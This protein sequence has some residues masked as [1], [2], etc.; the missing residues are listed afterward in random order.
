M[1]SQRHKLP[2]DADIR[3]QVYLQSCIADFRRKLVIKP[4]IDTIRAQTRERVRK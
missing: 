1:G 2:E 3:D 4:D